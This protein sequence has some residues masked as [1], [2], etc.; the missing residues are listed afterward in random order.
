[1]KLSVKDTQ[2]KAQGELEGTCPLPSALAIVA[3][4]SAFAL[5]AGDERSAFGLHPDSNKMA[6]SAV[7]FVTPRSDSSPA[8]STTP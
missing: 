3:T 4:G 8:D 2:G 1:M 7:T 6:A 5:A